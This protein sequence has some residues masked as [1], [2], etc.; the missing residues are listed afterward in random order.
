M[1][2]S[3]SQRPSSS[4]EQ[5]IQLDFR[6]LYYSLRQRAWLVA[7]C[8]AVAGAGAFAYLKRAPKIFEAQVV[9][10]VEQEE[11]K[12]LNIEQVQ[13]ENLQALELVKTIEQTLQ[14]RALLER[15][16]TA[17][18]LGENPKFNPPGPEP[19]PGRDELLKGLGEMISVKLR[20]GTRLIDMK[21]EHTDAALT[22]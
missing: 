16:F 14:N 6:A 10:Q 22:A 2:R 13:G 4:T 18:K 8:L 5:V 19:R 1:T 17:L 21:V 12:V 3:Q 7:L 9:L 20:R 11:Q 15:V